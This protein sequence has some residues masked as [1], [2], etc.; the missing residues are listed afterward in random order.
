MLTPVSRA[1]DTPHRSINGSPTSERPPRK[2]NTQ[3]QGLQAPAR[4]P[5]T[6]TAPRVAFDAR[7]QK[8]EAESSKGAAGAERPGEGMWPAS[9]DSVGG[10][11]PLAPEIFELDTKGETPLKDRLLQI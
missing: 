10:T 2:A 8:E 5:K 6:P 11:C 4:N 9:W 7:S 3:P 1:L